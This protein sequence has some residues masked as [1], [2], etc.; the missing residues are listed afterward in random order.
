MF[1]SAIKFLFKD[2]AIYG[3]A[4]AINKLM[5]VI[6]TPIILRFITKDEFGIVSTVIAGSLFFS[7][8]LIFGMDQ[9]VARWFFDLKENNIEYQKKIVSIGFAV[10]VIAIIF[11]SFLFFFFQ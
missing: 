10:H 8:L 11:F 5:L 2:S 7:G 1:K 9:A 4:G 3:I 6:S